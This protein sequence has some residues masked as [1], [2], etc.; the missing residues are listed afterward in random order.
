MVYSC[1]DLRRKNTDASIYLH[2]KR[3]VNAVSQISMSIASMLV[4]RTRPPCCA[5]EKKKDLMEHDI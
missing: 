2:Y 5:Q 4:V 3:C 1:E